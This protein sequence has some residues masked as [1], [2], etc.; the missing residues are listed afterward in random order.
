MCWVW[1][2]AVAKYV[3]GHV[4]V[5]LRQGQQRR[6]A[7][8]AGQGQLGRYSAGRL[9]SDIPSASSSRWPMTSRPRCRLRMF[10]LKLLRLRLRHKTSCAARHATNVN[11]FSG[12]L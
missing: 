2:G 3:F 1:V 8:A 6:D 12:D 11:I 4:L 9:P 10:K 7:A 5:A